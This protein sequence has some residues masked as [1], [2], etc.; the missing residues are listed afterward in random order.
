MTR[1]TSVDGWTRSPIRPLTDSIHA[2]H[3]PATLPSDA[4]WLILP[5]LPTVLLMRAN[6]LDICELSR[7]MSLRTS[8]ILPPI[9]V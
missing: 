1:A 5:S 8:L 9:P 2:D 7:K 6:S 4:R 3:P